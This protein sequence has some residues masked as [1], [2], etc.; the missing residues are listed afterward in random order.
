MDRVEHSRPEWLDYFFGEAFLSTVRSHDAETQVGCIITTYDNHILSKGYNGF[1]K[2]IRQDD[3]LPNIRPAKYPYVRHSEEN[4]IDNLMVDKH[5]LKLMLDLGRGP[6]AYVTCMPCER[7]ATALWNNNV[8][9]WYVLKGERA[10]M[11]KDDK[12]V[13][14]LLSNGL[15]IHEVTPDLTYLLPLVTKLRLLGLIRDE[16]VNMK[17][18]FDDSSPVVF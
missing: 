16:R 8:R 5:V 9:E 14:L 12:I 11:G 7:C 17:E 18:V 13:N 6:I 3:E 1:P 2:D 15:I 10:N 4:A